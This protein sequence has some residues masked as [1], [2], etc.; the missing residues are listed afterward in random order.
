MDLG[1]IGTTLDFVTGYLVPFVAVLAIVIFIHEMGHFLVGRW[2][3][4]KV[5]T[6]ALGFGPEIV[7]FHD[8]HGTRW[9]LRALPLGGFVKFFGD[10]DAASTPDGERARAMTEAERQV[11]F[12]HK[13]VGQ[14][15]AIVAAGPLANFLLA[16]A[17]FAGT[18]Y[19]GGKAVL[20]P[21]VGSLTPG[22]A[23]ERAG[24]L[25]G[26]R[27]LSIDGRPIATFEQ[28]QRIVV[29]NPDAE[30]TIVV[31]RN[32]SQTTLRATPVVQELS[33]RLGKMR[34]GMLGIRNSSDPAHF[35][36]Q[37][38]SLPEALVMGVAETGF[39]VERTITY[40]R[41]LIMGRESADQLSGP[42]RIAQVS[43]EVAKVGIAALLSLAAIL[44][45][46]IGL[47]NLFPIPLLDGG[48]LMFY[49]IEAVRRRPLSLR[50]QEIGFRV[51]F[52]MVI[53][54]MLF[55]TWNDILHLRSL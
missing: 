34:Q 10:A 11:S 55:A 48:H 42:I 23:A 40:I 22:G 36:V 52:A 46:S 51:G 44:S 32:G 39:V 9:S 24:F 5:E 47:I 19:I 29:A 2:C 50:A 8:R 27:I 1:V 49:A 7:G 45:V 25:P 17:I 3:G 12:F 16:I 28:L 31:D 15:A 4:V 13:S 20:E 38:Y 21:Y 35:R 37:T 54:M 6:F 26:D 53:M 18:F 33:S 30:L 41:G 43:G 14:R